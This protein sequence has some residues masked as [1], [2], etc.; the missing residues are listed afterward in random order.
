VVLLPRGLTDVETCITSY[1]VAKQDPETVSLRLDHEDSQ[2]LADLVK[3]EK[4][5]KS[6]VIR[7]ALRAYAE[8]LGVVRKPR[9]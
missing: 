4:L 9:R 3:V 1:Y 7:R 5:S 8:K 2:T 6:D